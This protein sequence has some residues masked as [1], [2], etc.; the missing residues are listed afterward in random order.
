VSVKYFGLSHVFF[1]SV[2]GP[3]C[4]VEVVYP[5]CSISLIPSLPTVVNTNRSSPCVRIACVFLHVQTNIYKPLRT[6]YRL[7]QYC[8][9]RQHDI[10]HRSVTSAPSL[11][12]FRPRLKTFLFRHSYPDQQTRI[13]TWFWLL[14]FMPRYVIAMKMMMLVICGFLFA[15]FVCFFCVCFMYILCVYGPSAWNKTDDDDDDICTVYQYDV[16]YYRSS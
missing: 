10:V 5:P 9:I 11:L 3:S 1:T 8:G 15:W 4:V 12:V 14:P 7:Q 13:L 16:Y 2:L 6:M